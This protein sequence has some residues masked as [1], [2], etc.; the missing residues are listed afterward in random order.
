MLL[1]FSIN[2]CQSDVEDY[3]PFAPNFALSWASKVELLS[4]FTECLLSFCQLFNAFYSFFLL[5]VSQMALE[6]IPPALRW[7]LMGVSV[8]SLRESVKL[9]GY[10]IDSL[11]GLYFSLSL[12]FDQ[13][14]GKK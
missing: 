5:H 6:S 12:H 13:L 1:I 14:R 10:E 11:F 2:I 4:L 3:I 7:G 9:R 8:I